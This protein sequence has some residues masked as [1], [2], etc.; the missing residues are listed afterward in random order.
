MPT[1]KKKFPFCPDFS[2]FNIW[3]SR[4]GGKDASKAQSSLQFTDDSV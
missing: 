2:T 4:K 1:F 3:A